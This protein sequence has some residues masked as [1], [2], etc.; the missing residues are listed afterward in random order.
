MMD[1]PRTGEGPR[2]KSTGTLGRRREARPTARAPPEGVAPAGPGRAQAGIT[3]L[4]EPVRPCWRPW[5]SLGVG[6]FGGAGVIH[7]A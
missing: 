4:V 1:D 5:G 2:F 3:R 6:E 7:L